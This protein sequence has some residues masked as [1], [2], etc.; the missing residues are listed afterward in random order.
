GPRRSGSG[1]RSRAHRPQ[2]ERLRSAISTPP[3][4]VSMGNDLTTGRDPLASRGLGWQNRALAREQPAT[5]GGTMD[6]IELRKVFEERA[7]KKVKV[8]G[9]DVDGVLRGKY[10]SLDKFWSTVEKGFGFCDV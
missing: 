3:P 10:V 4:E 5:E 9:F 8:G 1:A 7:I 2:T 6:T